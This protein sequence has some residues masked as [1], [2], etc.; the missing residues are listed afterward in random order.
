MAAQNQHYVPK[1]ILRQFLSNPDAERVSVYDKYNEKT[2]V[3]S[4]KNIMAERRFNEFRFDDDHI[5]SFEPIACRAEAE[6]LPAYREVVEQR[7][8]NDTTEQKSALA[9]LIAFQILRTR[10][11]REQWKTIEEELI[12]LIEKSGGRMQDVKGWEDWRPSTED[13]L[14]RD[15]LLSIQNSIGEYAQI[16]ATKDFVLAEPAPGR[17]FYLGD[18]PVSLANARGSGRHGNLGLAVPGIEIYLPLAADLM[19]CAWCP[20]ILRD[21]QEEHERGKKDRRH[22]AVARVMAGDVSLVEMERRLE[23]IEKIER[24]YDGL[25]AAASEGRPM[26]SGEQNMDYYNS[27]QTSWA[28]RY[29]VCQQADFK[30]ARCFNRENPALRSGRRLTFR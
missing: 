12:K 30:L 19:L 15:H 10:S 1:F 8:L 9:V 11:N 6:V 21:F 26:P 24:P 25:I 14:K 20:S 23:K 7:R 28:Y 22:E 3:T 16:I 17:S 4:I 29:I 13:S 5:A 27:L 2:F 18:N